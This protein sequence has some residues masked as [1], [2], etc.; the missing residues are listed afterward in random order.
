MAKALKSNR[1]GFKS[2][3]GRLLGMWPGALS[4]SLLPHRSAKEAAAPTLWVSSKDKMK[5][6]MRKA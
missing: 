3:N 4:V 5:Y 1:L 6:Y 2:W